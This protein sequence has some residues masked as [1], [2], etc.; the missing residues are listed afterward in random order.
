[1]ER[2]IFYLIFRVVLFGAGAFLTAAAVSLLL[3]YTYVESR[4]AIWFISWYVAAT[5]G[6][7]GG[8][9]RLLHSW[10]NVRS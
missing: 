9:F 10:N 2:K 7:Y 1:M 8:I 6:L 4:E 5:A 3:G